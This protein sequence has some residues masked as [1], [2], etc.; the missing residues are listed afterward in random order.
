MIREA[1]CGAP[2]MV[3]LLTNGMLLSRAMTERL[4]IAGVRSISVSLDGARAE[5]NDAVR[6]GAEFDTIVDHLRDAV[7]VRR[8]GGLDLR[9]GLSTV[10]LPTN[11]DELTN[12]VDL[13]ADIGLDW[14]KFEE[15]V[16]ATP[17][18]RT[19]LVQLGDARTAASVRNAC[20]RAVERGMT[21]VDHTTPMPRWVCALDGGEAVR[22][23]A[24]E[25]ANRA[26]LNPCRDAWDLA[27]IEPNGD[28]RMG[29][30]HGLLAG[31]LAEQDILEI[32]NSEAALKE[33]QRSRLARKCWGGEVVCLSASPRPLP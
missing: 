11:I 4:A 32:W 23:F 31:N 29:A 27:C 1:R 25:F 12:L 18:A 14:I 17:Y 26:A 33:R 13:A 15:L 21:A 8:E 30:F 9:L 10:V 6:S 22:H 24:D 19:S 28:V 5:T 2:T 3:H 16:P 7:R 20:A